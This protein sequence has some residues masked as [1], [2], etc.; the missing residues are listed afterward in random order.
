MNNH[1]NLIA[2]FVS[3]LAFAMGHFVSDITLSNIA[4]VLS[5]VCSVVTI[6]AHFARGRNVSRD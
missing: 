1:S 3:W 2:S 5:I 4:L 6:W